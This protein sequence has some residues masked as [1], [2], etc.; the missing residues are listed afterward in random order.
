MLDTDSDH[1]FTQFALMSVQ[2]LAD[3]IT[4]AGIG[5]MMYNDDDDKSVIPV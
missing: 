5:I 2:F 4:K 1:A 3:L